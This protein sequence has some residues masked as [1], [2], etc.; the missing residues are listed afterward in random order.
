MNT[1]IDLNSKICGMLVHYITS[2]VTD[3]ILVEI[4]SFLCHIL[5]FVVI[6][7]FSM[8]SIIFG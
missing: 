5:A 6:F 7:Y 8:F 3:E 2:F 1:E 4:I